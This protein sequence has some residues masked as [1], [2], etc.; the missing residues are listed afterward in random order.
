MKFNYVN[1]L[2]L[3]PSI[4]WFRGKKSKLFQLIF[5]D[6]LKK[7]LMIIIVKNTKILTKMDSRKIY[8]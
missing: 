2:E 1:N 7:C 6:K 5:Y 4:Y 8:L 3:F